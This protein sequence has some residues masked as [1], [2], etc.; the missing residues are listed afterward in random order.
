[1]RRS[2]TV[3]PVGGRRRSD[4][5]PESP[6]PMRWLDAAALAGVR[7]SCLLAR[8]ADGRAVPTAA[9]A[10]VAPGNAAS[11]AS[12]PPAAAATRGMTVM[13][14][15]PKPA[16]ETRGW[17]WWILHIADVPW[18]LALAIVP[19]RPVQ[20]QHRPSAG[21]THG[22]SSPVAAVGW[23]VATGWVRSGCRPHHLVTSLRPWTV[24]RGPWSECRSR[25]SWCPGSV[26]I[27]GGRGGA[28]A[29]R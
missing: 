29:C 1:M 16:P 22:A 4:A 15:D 3:G 17:D 19:L 12:A 13:E 14:G 9:R 21:L 26:W 5:D 25:Q 28:W 27:S 10:D 7:D 23:W 6:D 2:P 24:D 18:G 20:R 8:L 11:G